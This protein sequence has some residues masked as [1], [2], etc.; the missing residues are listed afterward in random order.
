MYKTIKTYVF[1]YVRTHLALSHKLQYV[2]DA[3]KDKLAV[4]GECGYN[5]IH[6]TPIQVL[7][8]LTW[9]LKMKGIKS[10][11]SFVV[12]GAGYNSENKVKKNYR[13]QSC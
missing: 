6:F 4:A 2:I 7:T 10:T 3:W 12:Y 11:Q 1:I 13:R 5:M 9:W 8:F